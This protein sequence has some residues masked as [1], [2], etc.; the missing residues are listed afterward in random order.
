MREIMSVEYQIPG[1]DE[2]TRYEKIHNVCV[3]SAEQG[4]KLVA[5]EIANSIQS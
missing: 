5:N 3:D 2:I 1:K 4:S